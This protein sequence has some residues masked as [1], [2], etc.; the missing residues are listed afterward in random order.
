VSGPARS[1]DSRVRKAISA[2]AQR[3]PR[4]TAVTIAAAST[5]VVLA[6]VTFVV[7]NAPGWAQAQKAFFDAEVF[8]DRLP[9]ILNAFLLNVRLF[10]TAE[11]LILIGG[12]VLAVLRGLP[13]PL[14][15]PIRVFAV[16]Y[17]D[18][19]RGLPSILVIYILGLGIP[20]L[21]I[22]G[23]SKDPFVWAIVALTMVWSA[24]VA[25]VYRAGI[26]S[27]H[28]SQDAAARSLGL[29]NM[30]SLRFVVLPQAVRRVIPP[31]LN[32]FIGLMKDTALISFIGPIEAFRRAQIASASTF[33][34][35]PYL[36]S[37]L[38]FLLLTIP[39]ARF[40]DWLVSR[41]RRRQMANTR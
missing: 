26:E 22:E 29:S 25:E 12:L 38:I 23:V 11:V 28:P 32:D 9:E 41:D 14:F 1:R 24:Y 27:V 10:L 4:A 5:I 19:M 40:V 15:F 37:A 33:N 3:W 21:N 6:V 36:V 7:V 18:V 13:G 30:Q 35:T 8:F 31:L 20:T 17:I 16:V 34:F 2:P 39:M